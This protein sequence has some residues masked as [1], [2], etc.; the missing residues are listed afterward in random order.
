MSYDRPDIVLCD[1]GVPILVVERTVE[2]PSGHN[3][4]Q[5]F[6]RLVAAAEHNTPVI[7]LGPYA[8]YKHGGETQGPRYMNLRL[9][10]ALEKLIDICSTPITIINWP[11][12]S[13]YEIIREPIKDKRIKKYLDVFMTH[14][15][16]HGMREIADHIINSEFEKEQ[17]KERQY[18]IDTE[19]KR[20][21]QYTAPPNSVRITSTKDL[22]RELGYKDIN[23]L[24]E[25][26]S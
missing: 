16:V 3:V 25:K 2:V 21:E 6:A 1:E 19:I 7:Y 23:N 22:S 8:A 26:T 20:P 10:Y 4:F 11:V 24:P 14:Y 18:F 12:D 9:F 13:N 17:K 5:R 15:K